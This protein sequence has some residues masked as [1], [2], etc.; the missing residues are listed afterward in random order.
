[1][2]MMSC[3]KCGGQVSTAAAF[4]PHCGAPVASKQGSASGGG[5]PGF[6]MGTSCSAVLGLGLIFFLLAGGGQDAT[7]NNKEEFVIF[8]M[9]WLLFGVSAA[10]FA[11]DKGRSVPGFFVLGVLLGPIGVIWALVTRTDHEA[12]R[13]RRGSPV[14]LSPSK[15]GGCGADLPASVR[16][17]SACGAPRAVAE[18]P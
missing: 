14:P 18:S 1:M 3:R 16:F 9:L 17:C 15:C 5:G 7:T 6:S 10:A 12:L 11:H 8:L 13:Q 2:V 4:C